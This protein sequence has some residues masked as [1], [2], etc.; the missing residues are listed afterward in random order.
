MSLLDIISQLALFVTVAISGSMEPTMTIGQEYS[1]DTTVS[2]DSLQNGDII[3]FRAPQQDISSPNTEEIGI[4]HR[5]IDIDY[6]SKEQVTEIVTKGDNE[7]TNPEPIEGIDLTEDID[8]ETLQYL[9]IG[10]VLLG[11]EHEQ[12]VLEYESSLTVQEPNTST[13]IAITPVL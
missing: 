7:K 4:T 5:I 10:K 12:A 2:L 3:A 13:A 6:N 9:Y 11:E 1:V 8:R